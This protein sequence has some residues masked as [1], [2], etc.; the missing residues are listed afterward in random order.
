M[1]FSITN[2]KIDRKWIFYGINGV[3]QDGVLTLFCLNLTQNKAMIK[4]GRLH[5]GSSIANVKR[6]S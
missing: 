6:F 4:T 3:E 5:K 1:Q 2:L